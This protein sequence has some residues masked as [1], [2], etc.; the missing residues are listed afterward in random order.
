MRGWPW[1]LLYLRG[2]SLHVMTGR[3]PC[4][5]G[6]PCS[7]HR[8]K[9]GRGSAPRRGLETCRG[10]GAQHTQVRACSQGRG[11]FNAEE[12]MPPDQ[13]QTL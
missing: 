9:G 4:L 5:R 10:A 3:K 1:L 11:P 6:L 8:V 7:G 13:M 12:A 2:N